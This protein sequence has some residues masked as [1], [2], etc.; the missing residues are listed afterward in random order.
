MKENEIKSYREREFRYRQK[1]Y[2]TFHVQYHPKLSSKAI[3][4]YEEKNGQKRLDQVIV[5]R[6]RTFK[7]KYYRRDLENHSS[8]TQRNKPR[9]RTRNSR[10]RQN[11]RNVHRRP[12]N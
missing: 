1:Q 10:T 9:S 11:L 7:K 8:Q 4:A 3:W 12:E 2:K 5:M 6:L